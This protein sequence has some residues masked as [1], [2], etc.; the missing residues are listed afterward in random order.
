MALART[1][2][3]ALGIV[4]TTACA[5]LFLLALVLD[6]FGWIVNPYVGILIFGAL[7][8]GFLLGLVLIPLGNLL[9]RRRGAVRWPAFD[10]ENVR[11]RR[12]AIGLLAA[13]VVN[14]ALLAVASYGA[15]HYMETQAFC[16]EV[17]HTVMG[18]EYIA[19]QQAPHAQV[20]CVACHV[21]D[22]AGA[23]V[24]SKVDGMRRLVGFVTG[25]IAR[26][27]PT[28]VHTMRPARETCAT[29]HWPAMQRGNRL[30]VIPSFGDDEASTPAP[31]TLELHVRGGSVAPGSGIHWHANPGVAIEYVATDAARQTIVA[32]RLQTEDGTVREYR[33]PGV[34]DAAVAAGTRRLMD[35]TDCH[36]R[37]S[38]T[39]DAS[40]ERAVD[41]A[42]AAGRVSR[43]VP[44]VRREMVAAL[45]RGAEA[46]R[47]EA[48]ADALRQAYAPG[49]GRPA[50]AAADV[51]RVVAVARSLHDSHV[52]PAMRVTWGTYRNE[53]GH[54]DTT[55]CF[56]CHDEELAT[57]EGRAISQDCEMCHTIRD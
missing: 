42:I 1:P 38:H 6:A 50:A 30:E 17:C 18:P 43:D 22:G 40:P 48:V 52:F 44:F 47:A 25:D 34:D 31:T 45:K 7:P 32:V 15:V 5:L 24:Q 54:T 57:A 13:T 16:G 26:P 35:C 9:G 37:P 12:F 53:L 21:G 27:I 46:G 55:G 41:R 33:R 11:H 14:I 2:L 23:L 29:C 39:F 49:D 8:A 3:A 28:P 10:L 4:L 56:R 19:Y 20:K 51:D 36:S